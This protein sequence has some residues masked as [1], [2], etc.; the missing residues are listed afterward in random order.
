M[1]NKL[2]TACMNRTSY[3]WLDLAMLAAAIVLLIPLV[4][5]IAEIVRRRSRTRAAGSDEHHRLGRPVNVRRQAGR[6]LR[7]D[8]RVYEDLRRLD[9]G[10]VG[11]DGVLCGGLELVEWI[12][13][14]ADPKTLPDRQKDQE[15]RGQAFLV[16]PDRRILR[17]EDGP[18]PFA[19]EEKFFAAGSGR[20]Y[21]LTAMYLGKT[22]R[23]AVEIACHFDNGCGNGID[24]LTF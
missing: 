17:Y 20:D 24:E 1:L 9:A 23:E 15:R 7:P 8:G 21:A 18:Y 19:V 3:S 4:L 16:T 22:A 11:I 6:E 5:K 10:L 2:E 12:K 13:A 14:G